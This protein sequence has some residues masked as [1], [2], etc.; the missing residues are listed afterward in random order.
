MMPWDESRRQREYEHWLE[1]VDSS[2]V[3]PT[4]TDYQKWSEFDPNLFWRLCCGDHLNLL[5]EAIGALVAWEA[6]Q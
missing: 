2:G 3:S 6:T 1:G 5:D 4:L